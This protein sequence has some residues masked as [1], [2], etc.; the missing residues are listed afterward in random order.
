[1]TLAE[2]AKEADVRHSY[3]QALDLYVEVLERFTLAA[4]HEKNPSVQ[5]TLLTTINAYKDRAEKI[6]AAFNLLP[7]VVY[8]PATPAQLNPP[9]AL[10]R[11]ETVS[12][13]P[14]VPSAIRRVSGELTGGGLGSPLTVKKNTKIIGLRAG[15][16]ALEATIKR[17]VVNRGDQVT[18]GIFVDNRSGSVINCMKVKLVRVV[19]SKTK[20]DWKKTILSRQEFFQGSIFPLQAENSYRGDLTFP[21]PTQGLFMPNTAC[22]F[23]LVVECEISMTKNLKA[24][25]PVIIAQ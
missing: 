14:A 19:G 2:K 3:Q 22:S 21:I 17:N 23:Y 8:V 9:T 24:K 7:R 16:L 18:I 12:N 10:G 20:K 13:L 5:M 11:N 25:L 6:K 15:T 1:L 4:S